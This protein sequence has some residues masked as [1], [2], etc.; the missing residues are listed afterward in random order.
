MV[1]KVEHNILT[2]EEI[3]AADDRPTEEVHVPEWGGYVRIRAFS[4]AQQLALRNLSKNPETGELDQNLLE[5]YMAVEGIVEPKFTLE[6]MSLLADKSTP[7]VDRV[8][9][10]LLVMSGG[11]DAVREARKKFPR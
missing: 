6:Q 7:A 10:R 9:T 5:M 1:G 8:I 11:T 2:V 4:K 3:V